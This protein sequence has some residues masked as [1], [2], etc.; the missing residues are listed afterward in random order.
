MDTDPTIPRQ[1]FDEFFSRRLPHEGFTMNELCREYFGLI[2][3][4]DESQSPLQGYTIGMN[5]EV[6]V[7]ELRPGRKG[8]E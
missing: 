8:Q 3:S 5:G 7:T 6:A 4:T 2:A 1:L